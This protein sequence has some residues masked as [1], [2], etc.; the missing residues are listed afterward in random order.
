MTDPTDTPTSLIRDQ[1]EG[2]AEAARERLREAEEVAALVP[3]LRS[4]LREIERSLARLDNAPAPRRSVG[5]TIRESIL[6]YL[7]GEGGEITFEPGGMLPTI[8]AAIGRHKSSVQVEIHRLEK[9]GSVII[10]R[11]DRGKPIGVRRAR[12]ALTA[13]DGDAQPAEPE[14]ELLEG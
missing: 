13:I 12:P 2:V 14:H 3:Q 10:S 9:N 5:P 8:H 11:D 1:L 6:A 4:Q 7:D